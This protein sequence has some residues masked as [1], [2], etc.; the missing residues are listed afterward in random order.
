MAVMRHT[1]VPDR[2]RRW[3]VQG[4]ER[5]SSSVSTRDW[6]PTATCKWIVGPTWTGLPFVVT[7]P[8]IEEPTVKKRHI[9]PRYPRPN[10]VW[11]THGQARLARMYDA[12]SAEDDYFRF[13][14][15]TG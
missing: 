11:R 5:R 6:R 2:H 10:L 1:R 9:H 4:P 3:P 12:T 15:R 7:E 14:N 8:G 13:A